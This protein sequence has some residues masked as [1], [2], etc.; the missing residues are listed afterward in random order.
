MWCVNG[1]TLT[2]I[3]VT[4]PYPDM[5]EDDYKNNQFLHLCRDKSED[6]KNVVVC[7]C[8][9]MCVNFEDCFKILKKSSKS[10]LI[11]T[12][13]QTLR[14]FTRFNIHEIVMIK[15]PVVLFL[16]TKHVFGKK[17][18]PIKTPNKL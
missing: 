15:V 1:E 16:L 3:G 10:N 4:D 13:E 8:V 7:V 14:R 9:C 6:E 2:W 18:R 5:E 12:S 17:L 11:I